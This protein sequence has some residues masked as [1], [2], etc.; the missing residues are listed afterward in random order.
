MRPGRGTRRCSDLVPMP[1]ASGSDQPFIHYPA[2]HT[3]PH[4]TTRHHRALLHQMVEKREFSEP[5]DRVPSSVPLKTLPAYLRLQVQYAR[6]AVDHSVWDRIYERLDKRVREDGTPIEGEGDDLGA[7]TGDARIS[8]DVSGSGIIA[9]AGGHKARPPPPPPATDSPMAEFGGARASDGSQSPSQ[10]DSGAAGD[11]PMRRSLAVPSP[12]RAPATPLD[13]FETREAHSRASQ[14]RAALLGI[15]G[16]G[17]DLGDLSD[18]DHGGALYVRRGGRSSGSGGADDSG[19]AASAG[20]GAAAARSPAAQAPRPASNGDARQ[21]MGIGPEATTSERYALADERS[22]LERYDLELQL[23]DAALNAREA[24]VE[25]R[26]VEL[27]GAAASSEEATRRLEARLLE[28]RKKYEEEAQAR[29]ALQRRMDGYD[30]LLKAQT[31][32]VETLEETLAKERASWRRE[33]E[34]MARLQRLQLNEVKRIH[35]EELDLQAR[36]SGA[37]GAASHLGNTLARDDLAASHGS[38]FGAPDPRAAG[39]AAGAAAEGGAEATGGRAGGAAWGGESGA[40]AL[41]NAS[42]RDVV[43]ANKLSA[44]RGTAARLGVASGLG[45]EGGGGGASLG[46][47]F[48]GRVDGYMRRYDAETEALASAA[49]KRATNEQLHARHA[50][51][52]AGEPDAA[53]V[54]DVVDFWRGSAGPSASE[55]SGTDKLLSSIASHRLAASETGDAGDGDRDGG[56]GGANRG[57]GRRSGRSSKRS[58]GSGARRASNARHSSRGSTSG[59]SSDGRRKRR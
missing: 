56:V 28:L 25:A 50:P 47:G 35:S 30:V 58:S 49:L 40:S 38:S 41:S 10:S 26:E 27:D 3:T 57:S 54:A 11:H 2:C 45:G 51:R 59:G 24:E 12:P 39:A 32:Q 55:Q 53:I 5:F 23:R 7:G 34:Q 37:Y 48:T 44:S 33:R 14:A 17:G 31:Q 52:H 4:N 42:M 8:A 6:S 18:G 43:A 1:F 16:P 20:A 46:D 29:A 19:T 21:H 15:H 22:R 13:E 9:E 36:A